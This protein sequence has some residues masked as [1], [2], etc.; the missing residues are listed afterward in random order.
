MQSLISPCIKQKKKKSSGNT[1]SIDL[2]KETHNLPTISQKKKG[3]LPGKPSHP[4][5]KQA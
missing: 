4:E 5:T 3:S 2:G 1:P